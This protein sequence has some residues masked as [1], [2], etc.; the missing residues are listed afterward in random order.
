M[1]RPLSVHIYKDSIAPTMSVEPGWAGVELVQD[2]A[3]WVEIVR[4]N[5]VVHFGQPTDNYVSTDATPR[6]GLGGDLN[7]ILTPRVI[8][9]EEQA[10]IRRTLFGR[11]V[12]KEHYLG[13]AFFNNR[14][15][16]NR[17]ALVTLDSEYPE[18]TVAHEIGHLLSMWVKSESGHCDADKCIGEAIANP[19]I[20]YGAFCV[21]CIKE[22]R[23]NASVLRDAKSGKLGLAPNAKV[24]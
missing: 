6:K 24:F 23:R 10:L 20:S 8:V 18:Q 5:D 1:T 14:V 12:E 9:G 15:N 19:E 7:V 22:L 16:G 3:P 13:W 17:T 2:I 21:G 11:R 4:D